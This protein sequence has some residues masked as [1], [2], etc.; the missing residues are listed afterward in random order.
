[1]T[2]S[3]KILNLLF[4][5]LLI[6]TLGISVPMVKAIEFPATAGETMPLETGDSAPA[7]AVRTVD[8]ESF[9]FE[10]NSL[11]NPVIGHFTVTCLI[12]R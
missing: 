3:R 7:F 2:I 9:N 12:I 8:N 4:V 1:M 11:Q 5:L 6:S 10:P